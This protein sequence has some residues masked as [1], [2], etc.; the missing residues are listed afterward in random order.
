MVTSRAPFVLSRMEL[1][2]DE[3]FAVLQVPDEGARI[4]FGGER[5]GILDA[6]VVDAKFDGL[7]TNC[8]ESE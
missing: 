3:R 4:P 2:N 5:F 1:A 8:I 6:S 7:D